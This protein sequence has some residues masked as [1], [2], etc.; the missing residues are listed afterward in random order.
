M[1]RLLMILAVA[2]LLCA[3]AP[4]DPVTADATAP[5][6]ELDEGPPATADVDELD[7]V[8]A[9]E[10]LALARVL[11]SEIGWEPTAE[12]AAIHEVLED[13]SRQMGLSYLATV[14]AYSR[15]C[16]PG[17][18]DARRWIAHLTPRGARPDGWPATASW[19]LHRARWLDLHRHAGEVLRGRVA[20]TCEEPPHYWGMPSGV[21]LRRARAA[22]WRRVECP[23]ARNAFW[24]VP[25]RERERAPS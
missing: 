9:R 14:C 2:A 17:R 3:A 6:V 13:R 20:S 5:A 24:R 1:N 22:G 8:D 18:T 23:G 15:T 7:Q 21:D 11:A 12:A 16:D 4:T 10:Q 25:A 19:S